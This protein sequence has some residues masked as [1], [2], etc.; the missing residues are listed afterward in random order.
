MAYGIEVLNSSGRKLFSTNEPYSTTTNTTPV[1]NSSDG[2]IEPALASDEILIARPQN[3]ESGVIAMI[4]NWPD[5]TTSSRFLGFNQYQI[6]WG[7]ARGV[8]YAKLKNLS[9]VLSPVTT[10]FGFEVYKSDG[11]LIFSSEAISLI[12]I[13]AVLTVPYGTSVSYYNPGGNFNNL[14]IVPPIMSYYDQFGVTSVSY[15]WMYGTWAHFD[16]TNEVITIVRSSTSGSTVSEQK[17]WDDYDL[18]TINSTA[19]PIFIVRINGS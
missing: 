5:S 11:S 9:S 19:V 12:S 7:A 1:S 4:R 2:L 15:N 6:N 14:Y 10:G 18:E 8:K 16:H 17:Y 3:N 13:E